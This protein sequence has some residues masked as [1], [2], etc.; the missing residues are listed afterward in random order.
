[1][2]DCERQNYFYDTKTI[3]PF[4]YID[5][6]FQF[7]FLQDFD[8]YGSSGMHILFSGIIQLFFQ[9]LKRGY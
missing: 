4:S 6:T 2:V 8:K 1:M 7:Q 5:E 3:R 9:Y